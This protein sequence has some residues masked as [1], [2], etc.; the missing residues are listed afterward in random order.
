MRTRSQA[1]RRRQPQV[2]QTSVESSNLEKP[3]NPPIVT[4][5]DNRTMAQL[6]EAPTEG[7]ED[8][9]VIPE[10]TANNFE[11]K[12]GLLNLVQ[13]K[14]FF[15]NDKED[16]HAHILPEPPVRQPSVESSNLEKPDNPPIVTMADNRTMA[17]LLEAPTEG[18]EDAIVIP[19]ITANN[20]EIKHG[21]LNLV[22]NKQFFGNDKEDPHAHIRYFNKIT[23]T[24]KIPNV[25][26]TS[27]KLMLFPFSL[28]G[29]A[30]IWLEKEPPRSIET[31]DDLVS[32]FINKFFP[33][34]KTTNLRNE[35]TRFQQ[36]FD[37]TF[38]EAWDRFNDLLRG[39]PHHGFSELHQLDTFY[40]ALNSN[41]QDSLNSAAGG[42]FLD[43]MPRECLKI[44][45]SK[46]K[47]RQ[48]R[49]KAVVAKMSTS[50]STPAISSDV[51]ELK[52]MV[53]ALILDRKNQTPAS[54]PVKAVEQ[55]CVT[56]GG[57]HSYQN[58]PATNSNMYH[59]NIQE[60]VSQAAA[61]NFNQANSGYRPPMVSNQIR[62][63]GFPPVQ[64]KQ[65]ES[66]I[67][68][69]NIGEQVEQFEQRALPLGRPFLRTACALI[70]VHGEQMTLRHNDQFVTFKVGDT[71]TFSYNIIESVNRV[72]V[73]D[74]ACE[75]YV[76]EVLEISESGNPTSPSDLMIDSRSPSFTPFGGSD[77]LMEEI[78]AFLENDD[79]IPP[80]VDGIY[81]SEGDTV[82][83]EELLSVINK[84]DDKLPIIIAKNLKDEDKTALIKV[85]KSHKH[86]IAWKISDIKGIDPQFCTHKI[87]M[88]ENAKPVVQH[89]R[90]VNP[91]IHE[92]IKQ[93]VIKLL[94][95]G[96]IY[97][98]S[99][100]PWVSPVH[101]V[102]K[103]GGITVVKNEEN[104]LI[105]TR[106]VTGW[107]VCIDYRKL[108]D[109]TRKD[110]F[111]LPFM[112]Q[113]L[114][115]LAGNEYYCFLDGFSGYFQIPIDPLDQEKTTF[116][117][118]YGTF[119]YRR[120]PFGLCNAPGTF[121]RCMVAIFHDMIEKTMEVFM[122]DFSVFGDSFSSCLSH[123]DK[124]LQRCEDTNLVLNWENS[125]FLCVLLI[126]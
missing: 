114:E 84:G 126:A 71:K 102:P 115:R 92:V 51:A 48:S 1:R 103:K 81:D 106:L 46:S 80:G 19:E 90:R 42:N 100:S 30:R 112:D 107:R 12:H 15:G 124:M 99:D 21:L 49:N 123:L 47:V 56:C 36:K 24:M 67:N 33:P 73:I 40:N 52:D 27:V 111:P 9:I 6:L 50:S 77:F 17:Q 89:Q 14:Q 35:I 45:E 62:P 34:S 3:D 18:Y 78:D 87:L 93:E 98:I 37:E 69:T 72:D 22:Q 101:C 8:A 41:D 85:L 119:A 55:S 109:A 57:G 2:R 117:C 70:D 97:P 5:A 61:A 63:P 104:E 11:I 76:Q 16:P 32:K 113:M 26:N 88:E 39:C 10:I 28:E 43:K 23:S 59:D 105:P 110:H 74:I 65:P 94:D 75:E 53:R 82:Y 64:K 121:Q 58:C 20:F 122:D 60:Y 118:P 116:T 95:A 68:S 13:N 29:A 79:S 83:L 31:W 125:Y 38:Y 7:Y 4:M 44:I 91:K 66:G 96:L 25:P 120:M 108:N 54:A 86:A